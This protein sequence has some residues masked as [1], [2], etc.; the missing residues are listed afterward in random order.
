MSDS[1]LFRAD[2]ADEYWFDEGCH[3]LE[4]VNDPSDPDVSIAR[5][6]VPAGGTTR[7]HSLENTTERYLVLSG[8]GDVEVGNSAPRSLVAGDVVLI[9]AGERQ[10]IHNPGP[11]VLEF[12]AICSPRFEHANYR[13]LES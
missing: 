5:A 8:T 1:P 4:M 13:D 3:I 10:R 6:R 7:W 2:E 9:R 11:E 12:L